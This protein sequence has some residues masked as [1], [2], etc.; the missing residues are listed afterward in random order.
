MSLKLYNYISQTI[1]TY[2]N[3]N[4]HESRYSCYGKGG[5]YIGGY[6]VKFS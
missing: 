3:T 2:N 4:D 1:K 6:I 5:G